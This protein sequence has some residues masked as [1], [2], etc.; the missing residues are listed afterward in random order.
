MTTFLAA[1]G[2]NCKVC[3]IRR[4]PFDP[5]AAAIAVAWYRERGWLTEGEGLA[6]ALER[7]LV[8]TG[9]LG[10]RASHW[11]PD[12]WILLCC[13]DEK[14]HAS[15]AECQAFPCDRLVAWSK[16]NEGYGAALA[17]L[18]GLREGRPPG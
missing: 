6:Q 7:R 2:L 11:S 15:C 3:E 17:R 9:C 12:C 16:Q 1:C 4:A 14:G 8:C 5:A 18:Q 10:D 13:V